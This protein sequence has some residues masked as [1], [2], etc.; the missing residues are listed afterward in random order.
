MISDRAKQVSPSATLA[1]SA[2]AAEMKRQGVDVVSFGAG[3]PDFDTPEHIKKAAITA[4]RDGFTKYTATSGIPELKQA[5]IAKFQKD[6][7]L[8]YTDKQILVSNGAKQCLYVIIQATI[9]P[10][11]EVIIPVPYWVSYEEMVKLASGKCV[12]VPSGKNFIATAN[13]IR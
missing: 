6:N 8:L 10:G 7:G 3:E 11:D 1:M 2:K 13:Q 5:I 9:N 4:I 12:F